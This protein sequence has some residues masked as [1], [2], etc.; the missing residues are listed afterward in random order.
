MLA[1]IDVR[2]AQDQSC[3]AVPL[4]AQSHQGNRLAAGNIIG[5]LPQPFLLGDIRCEDP[6]QVLENWSRIEVLMEVQ[7]K[8]MQVHQLRIRVVLDVL[9]LE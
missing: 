3:Q 4:T 7:R 2:L 8:Q 9:L 1:R 6:V 5:D